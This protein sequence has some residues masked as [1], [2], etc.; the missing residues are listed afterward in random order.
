MRPLW[1]KL[2]AATLA[3]APM[4]VPAAFA[5]GNGPDTQQQGKAGD[6]D[7]DAAGGAA[8][9]K[10]EAAAA[11]TQ[12]KAVAAAK[13][14]AMMP[15][16]AMSGDQLGLPKVS[17]TS[18]ILPPLVLGKPGDDYAASRNDYVLRAGQ[19]Y[20]MDITSNGGLEY[21]F[22]A[23]DFFRNI[24]IDQIVVDDLEVHMAGAP[25]WLEYDDKGTISVYFK[26]VQPG[27]YSWHVGDAKSG[28]G[29]QGTILIVR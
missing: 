27:R 19:A 21:K 2:M 22:Q 14:M 18:R 24:W 13:K 1:L 3:F 17:L 5:Q 23:S 10:A 7:G 11:A 12:D 29:M 20:R 9:T 28:K 8:Q 25:A 26:A 16:N 15:A 4:S 6:D